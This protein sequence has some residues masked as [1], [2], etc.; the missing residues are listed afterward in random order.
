M[1]KPL[2]SSDV[3]EKRG[4]WYMFHKI[5]KASPAAFSQ[6]EGSR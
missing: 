5:K 1:L 4:D 6:R 2:K 3:F